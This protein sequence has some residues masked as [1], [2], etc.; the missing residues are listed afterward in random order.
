M[1][2]HL[3]ELISTRCSRPVRPVAA[4]RQ[5]GARDWLATTRVKAGCACARRR[6]RAGRLAARLHPRAGGGRA[7]PPAP[8][9]ALGGGRHVLPTLLR[10]RPLW[11]LHF[12]PDIG[13]ERHA[14]AQAAD[15]QAELAA[16]FDLCA[17]PL[18]LA[19][20]GGLIL[21]SN[22]AFQALCLGQPGSMH[23]TSPA[24]QKLLGWTAAGFGGET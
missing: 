6:Q 22:A 4:A 5:P 3:F 23:E 7:A 16:W 12:R 8:A 21:R 2:A 14:R 10:D 13:S 24:M 15:A 19:D 18:L 20:D 1:Q 17:D 9:L 11:H